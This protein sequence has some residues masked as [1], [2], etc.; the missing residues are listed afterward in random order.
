MSVA[1][2]AVVAVMSGPVLVLLLCSA[3]VG[4]GALVLL[5]RARDEVVR[6]LP[7]ATRFLAPDSASVRRWTPPLSAVA[8]AAG[9]Y[10]FD[11]AYAYSR[12][13][14]RPIV[15]DSPAAFVLFLLLA[16]GACALLRKVAGHRMSWAPGSLAAVVLI[17][18]ASIALHSAVREAA[19]EV[20]EEGR[21]SL[22][23]LAVG[24]VPQYVTVVVPNGV[25]QPAVDDRT[26][27]LLG[28][29]DGVHALFDC[30]SGTVLRIEAQNVTLSHDRASTDADLAASVLR[31]RGG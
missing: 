20:R 22:A 8:L 27:L 10:A 30:R 24:I 15:Y 11:A 31:C 28:S 19:V 17:A 7:A 5:A 1:P 14:E 21:W 9:M 12:R 29:V 3:V 6:R 18:S 2:I 13:A 26:M 4:L 23:V 16:W 25:D